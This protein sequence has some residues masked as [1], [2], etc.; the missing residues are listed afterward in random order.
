MMTHRT[1]TRLTLVGFSL[2]CWSVF[3]S[4]VIVTMPIFDSIQFKILGF[5]SLPLG[6]AGLA[7]IIL[8]KM[9]TPDPLQDF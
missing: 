7:L 4:M 2:A 9:N 1:H 3:G 5:V 8:E 6:I